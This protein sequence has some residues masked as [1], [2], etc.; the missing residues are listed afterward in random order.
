MSKQPAPGLERLAMGRRSPFSVRGNVLNWK[1]VF[2][3]VILSL[4]GSTA[5]ANLI[6]NS[7]FETPTVTVGGFT[8]F[9]NGSTSIT[10]WTVVGREVSIVS[11]SYASFGLTFPA[12]D[13]SQWLDLTGD[14]SNA[15]EGVQQTVATTPGLTYDLSYFVGNQVNPG[16]PYG[17]TSTVKVLVDGTLIQTSTNSMGAG[18]TMQVWEQF[19]TSF[20][21][22]SSSTT[23][24]FM[25]GDPS[26]D[27][28]NGL[29]NIVLVQGPPTSTVPEPSTF[30]MWALAGI[31]IFS[32]LRFHKTMAN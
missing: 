26:S 15:A 12:E 13:G 9:L 11:T 3:V 22:A 31:L 7:S 1:I 32:F 25:N 5:R 20:V 19:N 10:G 21:A 2:G 27:N 17:M 4:L 14:L 6:T 16:G 30:I 23:V 18:G 28:T 24:A 8:N 29:D